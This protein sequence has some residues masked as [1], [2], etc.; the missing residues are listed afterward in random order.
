MLLPVLGG[1]LLV[2]GALGEQEFGKWVLDCACRR[3][4]LRFGRV[5][6]RLVLLLFL[7]EFAR[8]CQLVLVLDRHGGGARPVVR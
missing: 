2:A 1:L 7:A 3:R 6:C 5:H 8:G 4:C